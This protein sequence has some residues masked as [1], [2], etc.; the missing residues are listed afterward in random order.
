MDITINRQSSESACKKSDCPDGET[1]WRGS[2]LHRDS[3]WRRCSLPA[4]RSKAPDMIQHVLEETHFLLLSCPSDEQEVGAREQEEE[5]KNH[6]L[7]LNDMGDRF[8]T[9]NPHPVKP[10][11]E[12]VSF[13]K[14]EKKIFI[15][16]W[17]I[18]I[19][20]RTT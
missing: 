11:E 7:K 2:R 1:M 12:P 9:M 17:K 15:S 13:K 19:W 16:F 5:R 10:L 4:T 8:K 14:K 18:T 20:L 6:A 3:E